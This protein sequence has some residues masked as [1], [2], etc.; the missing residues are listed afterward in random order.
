MN[1]L[2]NINDYITLKHYADK[3]DVCNRKLYRYRYNKDIDFINVDGVFFIKDERSPILE[4]NNSG[5][6]STKSVKKLTDKRDNVKILTNKP[7]KSVKKLTLNGE[8]PP[9]LEVNEDFK[10]VKN[11]T[12][13]TS[14]NVKILTLK[15]ELENLLNKNENDC[16]ISDYQRIEEIK[17]ILK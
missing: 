6:P 17:E 9:V 13:N 16:S 15:E 2:V 10:N 3:Y 5:R 1:K 7:N 8:N 14:E 11:L 12:L 4:R